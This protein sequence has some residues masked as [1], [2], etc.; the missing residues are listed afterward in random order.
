MRKLKSIIIVLI[1]LLA[2]TSCSNNND[3]ELSNEEL[4]VQNSLWSYDRY[5]LISIIDQGNGDF[6][7]EDWI[8]FVDSEYSGSFMV[9]NE[10]GTGSSTLEQENE[11]NHWEWEITNENKLK[12]IFSSDEVYTYNFSISSEELAIEILEEMDDISGEAHGKY[13]FK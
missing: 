2:L 11:T 9:F 4:L 12:L 3:I 6:T 8:N 10:D 13:I 5:E 7:E 1:G